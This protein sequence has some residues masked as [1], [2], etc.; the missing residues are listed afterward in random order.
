M[1][2][3]LLIAIDPAF[4]FVATHDSIYQTR[5]PVGD[6]DY[7]TH[8]W[9]KVEAIDTRGNMT[10]STNTADFWTWIL[11]DANGDRNVNVGDAVFLISYIFRGGPPPYVPKAGDVNGD[12]KV[13]VGDAVYLISYIFRQ[14]PAP[15]VGC[16]K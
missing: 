2:Y 3:K 15:K 7:S 1:R 16:A 12:C 9:W 13:N 6:L 4:T 14:G 10:P 11:G 8:Y 5:Y